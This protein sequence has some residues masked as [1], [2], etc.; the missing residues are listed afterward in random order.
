[1]VKFILKAIFVAIIA[2]L[3]AGI[4]M[5]VLL[6]WGMDAN[7]RLSAGL[8]LLPIAFFGSFLIGLPVALLTF[9][10]I[11]NR[12]IFGLGKLAMLANL[13]ALGLVLLFYA[14]AREFGVIFYGIPTI[15]AANAFAI[16]GWFVIV[17][18]ARINA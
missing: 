4:P 8:R 9:S 15:L 14:L 18:P 6:T 2:A 5:V 17:K 10:R 16:S 12:D 11:R 1:M 7:L 3:V 13:V